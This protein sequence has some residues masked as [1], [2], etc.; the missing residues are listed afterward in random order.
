MGDEFSIEDIII[1]LQRRFLYFLIPALVL[2]PIG[3]GAVMLLPAEYKAQGTILVE[4]QQIPTDLV[5]STVTAYAQE[6]IQT[7]KQRV[8]TY[9]QLLEVADKYSLFPKTT[10]L[11]ESERVGIMRSHMNVSLI[12]LGGRR[13]VQD[14][15]IAFTVSYTDEE[16]AKAY[17]VANEFMT[18]FLSEDVRTR[19]TG[20]SNTTDFFAKEAAKMRDELTTLENKISNYKAEHADSLPENLAMNRDLLTRATQELN[21]TQTNIDALEEEKRFLE[22]QLTTGGG[23]SSLSAELARLQTD[24]ARLRANYHDNYP[25][26]IAKR[27]EIAAIQRQMAPS[28]DIQRLR[29]KLKE[30]DEAL[31]AA[32]QAEPKDESAI[33]LA[34]SEVE[35]A[36]NRLS[37][38]I[39]EE[40]RKGT[41]GAAGAQIEGR[42]AVLENRIRMTERQAAELKQKIADYEERIAKTPAVE[43]DL[44]ALTRDYNNV[45]NDYQ[46]LRTK[47]QD[48]QLAENLE[49]NQQAEKFSILEPAHRPE[50][51]TS[52]DRAKLSLLAIFAAL[53]AGAGVALLA[54]LLFATLRGRNHLTSVIGE[55]PIAVIPFIAGADDK[56]GSIPFTGGR[57]NRALKG[58]PEPA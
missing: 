40:T 39:A 38:K 55:H 15:T 37:D 5:R 16:P 50:R 14:N 12:S 3:I 43:R 10:R 48:A 1:I 23:D 24:L 33:A 29:D 25:E 6:R 46:K 57:S 52:P 28:A 30:A 44:S 27:D 53:G 20:A 41:S 35:T 9:N 13:R 42:L 49:E 8:M 45:T 21:S 19:T 32:E 36:R 56:K 34:E 18:L 11:S 22:S 58:A 17:L 7:I 54:E 4:S 47:Q 26:V 31:T 2:A 51:P